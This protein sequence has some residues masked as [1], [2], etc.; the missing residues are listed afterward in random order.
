M[1]MATA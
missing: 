1:D